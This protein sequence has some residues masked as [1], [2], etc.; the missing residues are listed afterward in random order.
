MYRATLSKV[1]NTHGDITFEMNQSGGSATVGSDYTDF[2]ELLLSVPHGSATGTLI[3]PVINDSLFENNETVAA[4][5]SNSSDPAISIGTS[6][7]TPAA[8]KNL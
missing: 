5:M 4:T 6:S 3:V 7:A 8:P 1:N 2:D